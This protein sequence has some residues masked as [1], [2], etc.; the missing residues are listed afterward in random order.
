MSDIHDERLEAMLRSRRI[1]PASP[2]L[3]ER[4]I[5]KAQSLP[6]KKTISPWQ[7]L[8][9]LCVEFHLPKPAY[10]VAT[11]LVFG[12]VIGF[13]MP[14]D[15]TSTTIDNSSTVSAQNVFSADE[16]LL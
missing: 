12:L 14:P 15:K 2:D 11:A 16:A 5:L 1:E 7:W 13:S 8:R 9:E 10:V 3:A 4:I 6:Q